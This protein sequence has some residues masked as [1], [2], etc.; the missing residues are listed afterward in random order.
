M[1]AD[2]GIFEKLIKAFVFLVLATAVL[3]VAFSYAPLIRQNQRVREE[4]GRLDRE[5]EKE[6]AFGRQLK[7][8]INALQ[9]DPRTV[10]RM[11]REKLGYAKPGETVARFESTNTNAAPVR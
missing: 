2:T 4:N 3:A 8:N 5:I 6:E 7:A 10:E 9:K 11:V 1:S